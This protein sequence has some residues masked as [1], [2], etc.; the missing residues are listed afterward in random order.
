MKYSAL[1]LAASLAVAMAIVAVVFYTG[2][3][4]L[5]GSQE[6]RDEG[7]IVV[8]ETSGLASIVSQIA[9][10]DSVNIIVLAEGGDPHFQELTPSL[11]NA[12]KQANL[13][14]VIPDS[15]AGISAA[16]IAEESGTPMIK[17]VELDLEWIYV[18]GVKVYHG[19]WYYPGNASLI[20]EAVASV[21]SSLDH[22]CRDEINFRLRDFKIKME[23]LENKYSSILEGRIMIGDLPY[24][25][26]LAEWLGPD[27]IVIL[28]PVHEGE[29][30]PGSLEEALDA[31][32]SGKAVVFVSTNDNYN[33]LSRAGE[34]L[35]A[36][37][38][39]AG[40]PIVWIP[41][42]WIPGDLAERLELVAESAVRASRG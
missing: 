30:S 25:Y 20:A 14:V 37:A 18:D 35:A 17:I 24:L 13:V 1:T 27:S 41:A 8:V 32:Y 19:P 33:A 42:P 4:G 36:K 23:N 28:K 15:P 2:M 7:M 29:V 31:I 12:V 26:Y 5:T 11:A 9:C 21:L 22:D 40:A 16:R 39:E 3:D 34:W 38:Q 10:P 6:T